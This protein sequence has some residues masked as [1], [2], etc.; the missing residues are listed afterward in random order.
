MRVIK[1]DHPSWVFMFLLAAGLVF[2]GVL[3]YLTA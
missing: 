3:L 2:D 1:S